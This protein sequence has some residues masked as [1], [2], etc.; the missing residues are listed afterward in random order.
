MLTDEDVNTALREIALFSEADVALP[1]V[2]KFIEDIHEKPL[3][4]RLFV[5][6]PPDKWL[7]RLCMTILLKFWVM[8]LNPNVSAVAFFLSCCGLQGSEDNNN[9]G[10]A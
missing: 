9:N 10:K 8:L 7:L 1:V 2:K 3:G 5:V 4:M 6:L